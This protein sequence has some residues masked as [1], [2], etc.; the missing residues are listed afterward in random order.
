[1][2]GGLENCIDC[3]AKAAD[4]DAEP[5][6]SDTPSRKG[7]VYCARAV[8]IGNGAPFGALV[9]RNKCAGTHSAA[10]TPRETVQTPKVSGL[11]EMSAKPA[12]RISRASS[13]GPRNV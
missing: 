13:A 4:A 1:M 3:R 2:P 8:V 6:L 11:A 10:A 9:G 12:P 7:R 5:A